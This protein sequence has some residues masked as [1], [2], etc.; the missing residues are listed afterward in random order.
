MVRRTKGR[1]KA[2]SKGSVK[3]PLDDCSDNGTYEDEV[4]EVDD[5][6]V[7]T[8]ELGSPKGVNDEGVES[9]EDTKSD[10]KRIELVK[11]GLNRHDSCLLSAG[12]CT[13]GN[14]RRGV[15]GNL[16]K[17][18][19]RKPVKKRQ[20]V[21][22]SD[23]NNNKNNHREEARLSDEL[24]KKSLSYAPEDDL[25]FAD[26]PFYGEFYE[27]AGPP[28]F[29]EASPK[30]LEQKLKRYLA[31]CLADEMACCV[32]TRK[33]HLR[34]FFEIAFGPNG[35]LE[36]RFKALTAKYLSSSNFSTT[37][38]QID[39]LY[40]APK[41]PHDA[42]SPLPKLHKDDDFTLITHPVFSSAFYQ[43][44][45]EDA[46]RL[47]QIF[48]HHWATCP[49]EAVATEYRRSSAVH[50]MHKKGD[51]HLKH[52]INLLRYTLANSMASKLTNSC[53][54]LGSP[55]TNR[56][57]QQML[58]CMRNFLQVALSKNGELGVRF[59]NTALLL[60]TRHVQEEDF[61]WKQL[62]A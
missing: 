26:H 51:L 48:Y 27:R 53:I 37:E 19:S 39:N 15:D 16:E 21:Q 44:L 38:T 17:M 41:K 6:D 22:E 32:A 23:N 31:D 61:A 18:Y 55:I 3:P 29:R 34:E 49:E 42:G 33:D 40:E 28:R 47:E 9:E 5:E 13:K 45:K 50:R 52:S 10:A 12:D 2:G 25:S 60:L 36:G 46:P 43:V 59:E 11:G 7:Q 4:D 20:H 56:L 24:E 54:E 14:K 35:E 1:S 58:L 8:A 57:R 62:Y 30:E